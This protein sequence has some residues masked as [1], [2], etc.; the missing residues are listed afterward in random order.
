MSIGAVIFAILMP[1]FLQILMPFVQ[2]G[3]FLLFVF[4]QEDRTMTV[5]DSNTIPDWC[6]DMPYKQ[7]AHKIIHIAKYYML[8]MRVARPGWND[9]VYRWQHI[10]PADTPTD[11]YG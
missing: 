3:M 5:L 1:T 2:H 10:L 6:K 11:I 8:A 9:D 7:Y 4:D